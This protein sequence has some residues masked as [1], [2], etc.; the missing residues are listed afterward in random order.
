MIS[1][2]IFVQIVKVFFVYFNL[3]FMDNDVDLW[4]LKQSIHIWYKIDK[5]KLQITEK[6]YGK[7]DLRSSCKNIWRIVFNFN[8]LEKFTSWGLHPLY[9]Q[10]DFFCF[11][12]HIKYLNNK[13]KLLR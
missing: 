8:K 2:L 4:S 9:P 11:N 5:Y 10:R 6:E 3:F 12:T 7:H 1:S 13:N